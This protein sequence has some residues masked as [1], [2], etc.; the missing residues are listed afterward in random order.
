MEKFS[1]TLFTDTGAI[2]LLD[3]SNTSGLGEEF[4]GALNVALDPEGGTEQ[5]VELNG[6]WPATWAQAVSDLRRL[7]ADGEFALVLSGEGTFHVRVQSEDLSAAERARLVESFE[8]RVRVSSGRLALTD[9]REIFGEELP[10]EG[11]RFLEVPEG[12]YALH[13]HHLDRPESLTPTVGVHGSDEHPAL[14]LRLVPAAEPAASAPVDREFPRLK[15]SRLGYEEPQAGWAC[16]A[17]VTGIEDGQA[18]LELMLTET[19]YSGYARMS[20]P[21]G[22]ELSPGDYVLVRLIEMAGSYWKAEWQDEPV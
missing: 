4:V 12:F 5:A 22:E 9:G 21:E 13:I 20:V 18:I 1:F 2:L 10:G 17:Q 15:T 19:V 11:A 8:E 14:V 6:D 16:Y 7:S 3:P